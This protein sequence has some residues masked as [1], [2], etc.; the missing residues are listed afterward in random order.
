MTVGVVKNGPGKFTDVGT[1]S[2]DTTSHT[3]NGLEPGCM[4]IFSAKGDGPRR[5][6]GLRA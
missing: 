2:W 3:Y 4:Y 1:V 6:V 5:H